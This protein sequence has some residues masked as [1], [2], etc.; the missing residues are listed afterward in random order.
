MTAMSTSM[1]GRPL[2]LADLDD[3]PDDSC[4]YELVDGSLVVSPPVPQDH[5]EAA[6][7]LRDLLAAAAPEGWRCRVEYPLAFSDDTLRVPDVLVYRWPLLHPRADARSPV[8]PQDVGLLVEVVSASSRKTDR[9]AKPG[10]YAE[11]GIPLYWRLETENG[12][13]LHTFVNDGGVYAA[14]PIVT[15]TGRVP[16]PW[17]EVLVDLSALGWG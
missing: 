1:F 16:A 4:R 13:S 2:T 15:G 17:G 6:N 7:N 3:L 9:F 14:G 12:Y 10:E 11:A 8:G 5:Q